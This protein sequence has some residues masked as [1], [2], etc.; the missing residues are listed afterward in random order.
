MGK[1]EGGG[2]GILILHQKQEQYGKVPGEKELLER[3]TLS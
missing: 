2:P 1:E 3:R